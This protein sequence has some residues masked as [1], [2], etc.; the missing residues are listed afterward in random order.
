M[1]S[2][3]ASPV[4]QVLR[5]PPTAAFAGTALALV[6]MY[7]AAGAPTPLFV[8]FE[9]R[10]AFPAWVLTVAFATY[11]VGLLLALL[12]AGSL[13]D[14]IGRRPVLIGALVVELAAMVMFVFAP[15]IG[16]IIAARAIQGIATGAA[17]SAFTASIVELAPD[18]FKKLGA[19]VGGTAPAAGLAL[20]ALASGFAVQFSLIPNVIIFS[21]LSLVMI[22]G[23]AVVVLSAETVT[24][25]PGVRA[26]LVP[27]LSIPAEARPEFAASI[28]VHVAA[29]MLAGL[30][31]GLAPSVIREVFHI[32]SGL[33]NGLAAFLEPAAAAVAGLF[34]GR[35]I[36]RRVT[37]L[38]TL[39][40]FIGVAIIVTSIV[41]GWLPLLFVGAA[42]GGVGFGASFSGALRIIGPLARADQRAELFAA[43]FLVAYLAFGVPALIAGQLIAPF[44]LLDTVI[45]YGAV[46][47]VVA[48]VGFVAQRRIAGRQFQS[49]A[50]A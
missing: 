27:R 35:V 17:S 23:I 31:L 13:S 16:W 12:V 24:P 38:G 37:V 7:L 28:P 41:V 11:A 25:R 42:V 36:A 47:L 14:H 50:Q 45:G 32:D 20:G 43:V 10:W 3:P 39:L 22:L 46:T 34:L 1:S 5:L 40:V 15:N 21:A 44:G 6:G 26:S 33:V 48:A 30:F 2:A 49:G 4:P 8:L 18:R 29:W 19:V 9:E